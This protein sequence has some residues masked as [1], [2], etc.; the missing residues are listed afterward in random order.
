MMFPALE[1][2]PRRVISRQTFKRDRE[3]RF[4]LQRDDINS[5]NKVTT[6]AKALGTVV[7]LVDVGFGGKIPGVAFW[8]D[9]TCRGGSN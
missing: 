7:I 3:V 2:S 1:D 4:F 9:D 6:G 8:V 5:M